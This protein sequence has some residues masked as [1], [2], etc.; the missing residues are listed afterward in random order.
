[1]FRRIVAT[2][3]LAIVLGVSSPRTAAALSL[4]PRAP[5]KESSSSPSSRD[6]IRCRRVERLAEEAV[7]ELVHDGLA[8]EVGATCKQGC[9]GRAVLLGGGVGGEPVGGEVPFD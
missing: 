9:E 1:M 7:D 8:D 6:A 5:Y 2:R 3:S 4:M